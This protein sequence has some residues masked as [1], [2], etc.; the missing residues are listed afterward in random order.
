MR[1]GKSIENELEGDRAVFA[2]GLFLACRLQ[3]RLRVMSRSL[4]D[5]RPN[6]F[7]E[8]ETRLYNSHKRCGV[9]SYSLRGFTDGGGFFRCGLATSAPAPDQ[10]IERSLPITT[11]QS[12]RIWKLR[13][14]S[15]AHPPRPLDTSLFS[16]NVKI[17]QTYG[18]YRSME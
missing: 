2:F 12:N 9:R 4:L 16:S 5:T 3:G 15:P 14:L 1:S 11:K 8:N 17:C 18:S 10:T 7:A 13:R 6:E